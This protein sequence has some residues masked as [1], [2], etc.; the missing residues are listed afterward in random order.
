MDVPVLVSTRDMGFP[1]RDGVSKIQDLSKEE[2]VNLFGRI[3]RR[4]DKR[5]GWTKDTLSAA[6][7]G[8][9]IVRYA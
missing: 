4:L 7:K 9:I 5:Y 3:L 8:S 2:L 6:T 1:I